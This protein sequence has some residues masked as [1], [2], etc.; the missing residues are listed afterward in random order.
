MWIHLCEYESEEC[1]QH[2]ANEEHNRDYDHDNLTFLNIVQAEEV[3][4]SILSQAYHIETPSLLRL[5]IRAISCSNY[6]SVKDESV[7]LQGVP[8]IAICFI[9]LIIT[10]II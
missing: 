2:E 1:V 7:L 3:I 4:V 9:V 8:S 10:I 5:R 6:V